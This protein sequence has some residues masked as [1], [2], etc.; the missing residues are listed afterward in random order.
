M[1]DHDTLEVGTKAQRIHV[2]ASPDWQNLLHYFDLAG[3]G[4]AFIVLIV[5]DGDWAD[6]CR[7]ALERYLLASRQKLQVMSFE[8]PEEFRDGLAKR[9]LSLEPDKET[10]A[11]WVAAAIPEAVKGYKR[12]AEA[13]RTA[14]ARLNQHRNPLR[15]Q[16]DVPLLFVGA[17]WIQTVLREM[18]PDLW[19][20]R[21]LVVRVAPPSENRGKNESPASQQSF[22][23][24]LAE[25]KAIDPFFALKEAERF[26]GETGKEM[27]LARLLGRAGFGF[28]ARYQ[29]DEAEQ[30]LTEAIELY[31]RFA[32]ET[33]EFAD[34]LNKLAD[35]L[36]WKTDYERA[37]DILLEALRIFQQSG[38]VL[39]EANCIQS[40]GE[41]AL[42]RSQHDEA[43]A[44]YEE[45]LPLYRQ[46]GS[47]LGEANCIYSLGD[48]ALRR[49]QHDEARA[50]YEE[51]LP[52]YRQVGDVIGEANCIR[53]L[54]DIAL[55]QGERDNAKHSFIKALELYEQIP[56][57]YSIGWAR[58][59][60]AR[61]ADD[62]S[63]RQQHIQAARAAWESIAFSEL[64]EDLDEEFST[65]R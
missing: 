34:L 57:P 28:K 16:L 40:L 32:G 8:S 52:L 38:N 23:T 45:A 56:E 9:L 7:Q 3:E 54:G 46:V 49:S 25:G 36:Q 63:E 12:W 19:S 2:A 43:R 30:A 65:S 53:S 60:L 31:R 1:I 51:A 58:R 29:W 44:R 6:A 24:D 62:E 55:E 11:I 22:T 14:V 61:V 64:V 20:V 33:T 26:R 21:T 13:W 50:R 41:I 5:P 15:Q 47:V 37:V 27:A 48:I 59:R 17:P 42:R 18:A 39:G 4:F 10:G 35:V